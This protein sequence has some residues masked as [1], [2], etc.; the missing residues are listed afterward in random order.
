[1]PKH[2]INTVIE[3]CHYPVSSRISCSCYK[4]NYQECALACI[5]LAGVALRHMLSHYAVEKVEPGSAFFPA[6]A[7]CDGTPAVPTQWSRWSEGRCCIFSHS[8]C[9]LFEH[10]LTLL[11]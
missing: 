5:R 8:C 9:C 10:G 1:M 2:C 11:Q 7:V 3:R 4:V 6:R